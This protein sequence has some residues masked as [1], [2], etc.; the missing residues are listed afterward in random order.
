MYKLYMNVTR[1]PHSFAL[2]AETS[3]GI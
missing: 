3:D 2:V 1:A